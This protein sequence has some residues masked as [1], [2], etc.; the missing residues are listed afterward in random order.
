MHFHY[1]KY[2]NNG[3]LHLRTHI[4]CRLE[5]E[6][7]EKIYEA[8]LLH[9]PLYSADVQATIYDLGGSLRLDVCCI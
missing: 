8:S 7:N 4:P 3:P 9:L 1:K 6:K 2:L 5:E